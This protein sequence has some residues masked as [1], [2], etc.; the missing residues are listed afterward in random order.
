MFESWLILVIG[1]SIIISIFEMIAPFGKMKNICNAMF[2]IYF[3][4]VVLEP[5]FALLKSI[6]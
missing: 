2:G 6:L 4:Y 1:L 3:V 5:V